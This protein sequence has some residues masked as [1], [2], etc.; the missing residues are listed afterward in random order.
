MRNSEVERGG[1]GRVVGS[2]WRRCSECLY[3]FICV[4]V[5][6]SL[7]FLLCVVEVG[8]FLVGCSEWLVGFFFVGL[9][10][11][12]GGGGGVGVVLG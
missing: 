8:F 4:C 11:F 3:V 7:F 1:Y 10:C 5:L 9:R 6:V 12:G 2:L